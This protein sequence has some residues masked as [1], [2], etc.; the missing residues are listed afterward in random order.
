MSTVLLRPETISCTETVHALRSGEISPTTHVR[1]L[2]QRPTRRFVIGWSTATR[3][4]LAW[5]RYQRSQV[6]GQ[7]GAFDWMPPGFSSAVKGRFVG[8]LRVT[9][10]SSLAY[11]VELEIEETRPG[12]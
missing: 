7:G 4:E 11:Q 3:N 6:G 9:P 2:A 10:Q 5:I 8:P 12:S 1:H